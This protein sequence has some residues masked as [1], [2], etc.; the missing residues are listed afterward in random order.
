MY[1]IF[2]EYNCY[3]D[4][5]VICMYILLHNENNWGEYNA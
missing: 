5:D 1:T 2:D 4:V 3:V